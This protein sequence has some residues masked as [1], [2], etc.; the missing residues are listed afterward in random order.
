[1]K[2]KKLAFL[3][4]WGVVF[5]LFNPALFAD[6]GGNPHYYLD[7]KAGT[8]Y[9]WEKCAAC[10]TPH[11]GNPS[12]G[13][14]WNRNFKGPVTFQMYTSPTMNTQCSSPPSS[15][16]LACL[17]CHDDSVTTSS[18]YRY[19]RNAPGSG[20]I[21]GSYKIRCFNCHS[22]AS[23]GAIIVGPDLR[24]DHPISMTYPSAAQDP[25]FN[26]PPDLQRG[27]SDVRLFNGKVEC[28]SCHDPHDNSRGSYLRKSNSGS[29]LCFTCHIK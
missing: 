13:P 20:G 11:G 9:H 23:P 21:D 8:V 6:P 27:W 29:A 28:A 24:D 26:M 2:A 1:M 10:H 3:G 14:L 7:P 18:D 12:N 15:I 5:A 4:I 22:F 25:A 16:S 19:V 17:T